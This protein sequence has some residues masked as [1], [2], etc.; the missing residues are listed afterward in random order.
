MPNV[1]VRGTKYDLNSA[2]CS[3]CP[4]PAP[5]CGGNT[6]N[7]DVNGGVCESWRNFEFYIN[8][9][10]VILDGEKSFAHCDCSTV[11]AS[12]NKFLINDVA[13]CLEGDSVTHPHHPTSQNLYNS[14]NTNFEVRT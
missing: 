10:K 9:I 8:G 11:H 7:F 14:P 5:P 2:N 13:I 3:L 12:Q 4:A 1:A 6:Y